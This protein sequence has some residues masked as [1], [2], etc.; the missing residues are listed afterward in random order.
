MR[1]NRPLVYNSTNHWIILY[2]VVYLAAT[3]ASL[4]VAGT[5]QAGALRVAFVLFAIV[6][7]NAITTRTQLDTVLFLCVA[8][9][10]LVSAINC[11]VREG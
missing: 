10:A 4:S 3:F 1:R 8:V 9:A 5:L 11:A 2:A 6:L 7:I